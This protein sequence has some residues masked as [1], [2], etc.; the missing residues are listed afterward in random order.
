MAPELVEPLRQHAGPKREYGL[1]T[2]LVVA[3]PGSLEAHVNKRLRRC[4]HRSR[5]DKVAPISRLL[6]VHAARG[7]LLREEADR[8]V[9]LVASSGCSAV[10]EVTKGL[11]DAR[12]A[13]IVLLKGCPPLIHLDLGVRGIAERGNRGVVQV[14]AG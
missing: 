3:T 13:V 5:P 10:A 12:G 7:S 1:A 6:V 11:E 4:F 2:V 8:C 14:R 9:E